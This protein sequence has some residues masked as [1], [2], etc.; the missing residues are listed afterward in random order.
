MRILKKITIE[1]F[2]CHPKTVI[3]PSPEGLTVI[4]GPTDHGKSAIVRAIKWLLY[5]RP[6]GNDFIRHGQNECKVVFE[7][8]DGT[9]VTR[10]RTAS[11]NQYYINNQL[12]EGFG[13]DIPLE[14]QQA[15]GVYHYNVADEILKL[16][17]AEQLA[18][19]F[20][21]SSIS[22]PLRA[23]I[24]GKLAGTEDIDRANKKLGSDIFRGKQNKNAFEQALSELDN[25]I[26]I[27]NWVNPLG[28]TLIKLEAIYVQIQD[29]NNRLELLQKKKEQLNQLDDNI[30]QQNKLLK[31]YRGLPETFNIIRKIEPDIKSYIDLTQK[32]NK[33]NLLT[34][35]ISNQEQIIKKSGSPDKAIKYIDKAG[36]QLTI[37]KSIHRNKKQLKDVKISSILNRTIIKETGNPSE[38]LKILHNCN[39][40]INQLIYVNKK[41]VELKDAKKQIDL[42]SKILK[43][44]QG[45]KEAK[46]IINS[47]ENKI[48][49]LLELKA[50]KIKHIDKSK[51]MAIFERRIKDMNKVIRHYNSE[52]ESSKKQYKKLL[53]EAGVCPT[54]GGKVKDECLKTVI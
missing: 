38:A 49:N 43:Q 3:K 28:E 24:L 10:R 7:Y 41:N 37:L 21:G 5:N 6:L 1:N 8:E 16:N 44:H 45:I 19:P 34:G 14:V 47:T 54:C 4:T 39:N 29:D 50:K 42:K 52:L 36:E 33:W 13:N 9:T 30:Q 51:E 32:N 25:K 22:A 40:D 27:Y 17:I 26:D 23:K 2:Q 12:Y 35:Q 20:L 31:Q 18:G 15:T 11:L 46:N 48:S 53:K